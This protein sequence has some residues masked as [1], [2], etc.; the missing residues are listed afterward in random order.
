MPSFVRWGR[1][2]MEAG[3]LEVKPR[4]SSGIGRCRKSKKRS[5]SVVRTRVL[6]VSHQKG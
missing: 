4:P 1:Q 2:L 6:P 3:S 5:A